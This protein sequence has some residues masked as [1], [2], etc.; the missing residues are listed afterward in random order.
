MG[1]SLAKV[2]LIARLFQDGE[3][4][5]DWEKHDQ[6]LHTIVLARSTAGCLSQII[7]V[8]LTLFTD[9]ATENDILTFE[10]TAGRHFQML[11]RL[12]KRPMNS[13]ILVS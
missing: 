10:L 8:W 11:I 7:F 3:C 5:I 1:Q 6:L 13:A 2:F 12:P 4:E 9:E